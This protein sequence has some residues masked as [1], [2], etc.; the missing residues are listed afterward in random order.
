MREE[1][2][3]ARRFLLSDSETNANIFLGM[4]T[5]QQRLDEA[6]SKRKRLLECARASDSDTGVLVVPLKPWDLQ[7]AAIRFRDRNSH[8]DWILRQSSARPALFH[9]AALRLDPT[10]PAD[11]PVLETRAR[12]RAMLKGDPCVG[13]APAGFGPRRISTANRAAAGVDD[14]SS[15]LAAQGAATGLAIGLT[16]GA[17]LGIALV[18]AAR[19][20]GIHTP[21]AWLATRLSQPAMPVD[22]AAA[23]PPSLLLEAALG[24]GR[25]APVP[26]R[27]RPVAHLQVAS[28]IMPA[29]VSAETTVVLPDRPAP[30]PVP[31]G[32]DI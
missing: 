24:P 26:M 3:E 5:F 16:I 32:A 10:L 15:H 4:A 6:R 12:R 1:T 9:N 31:D 25:M 13:E 8:P 19:D 28:D 22:P 29:G 18:P 11:T 23:A 17:W 14:S 2:A 20:H 21:F 27:D 30:L 7:A